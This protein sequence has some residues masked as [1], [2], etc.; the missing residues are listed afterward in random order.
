MKTIGILDRGDGRGIIRAYKLDEGKRKDSLFQHGQTRI[1]RITE[2]LNDIKH[3]GNIAVYL[4]QGNRTRFL[5]N[6]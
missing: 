3:T 2:A 1:D 4:I 5:F 6:R